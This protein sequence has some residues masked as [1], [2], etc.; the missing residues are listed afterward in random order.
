[1]FLS[2]RQR[3]VVTQGADNSF[4][5]GVFNATGA[6]NGVLEVAIWMDPVLLTAQRPFVRH[7]GD[8]AEERGASGFIHC[9]GGVGSVIAADARLVRVLTY[10]WN[11]WERLAVIQADAARGGLFPN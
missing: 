9:T 1:M 2:D 11:K 10:R 7:P 3:A 4:G 6:S 8:G 5:S